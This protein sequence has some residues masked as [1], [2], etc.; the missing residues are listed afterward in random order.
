VRGQINR[1]I[2]ILRENPVDVIAHPCW[3]PLQLRA[4]SNS[5]HPIL[6]DRGGFC[7]TQQG[8]RDDE[9]WA[10]RHP[11]EYERLN[12]LSIQKGS[13]LKCRVEC[14]NH[15]SWPCIADHG[16]HGQCCALILC[17]D[18]SDFDTAVYYIDYPN[19]LFIFYLYVYLLRV[20]WF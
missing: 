2:A 20:T 10:L 12:T 11:M 7:S 18:I 5:S 3:I 16:V 17:Q 8:R 13:N 19:L 14:R 1:A 6:R 15:N 9:A 4:S